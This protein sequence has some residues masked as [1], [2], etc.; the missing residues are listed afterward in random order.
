[1]KLSISYLRECAK[2]NDWLQ[3]I[4]HSQLHNYHPAEV[5]SLIQY[6]SPVIQDHLRLAFENLPLVPTSKM[7]INQVCNKSS[8]E[9][10]GSKEVMTDLFE[11]LL[12]CSE[13]PDSWHWLLV[14]AVKQQ[15]PILSV[16]ASCLQG[17]SAISCLCVWI[18]TSVE[19][20]VATEAMGHI[21]DSIEDHTWNLEDLSVIWRALLTRQK[22]KTLIR[23][24]QLFF[25]DSPLLLV[26]EMYELCMFFKNYKE[27]EAKLLEFQESL[28]ILNTAATKVH[29]VIPA[30][31]LEDQVCFLLK[32]MLQQCKTPY[33]L[34]KLLQLF[35]EREHLFSD[36]PDV[37]KLYVLCQILKDTSIAINHIIITCYSI[38]NF[39]HECKS[40]LE[41]LQTDGQFAL[42]RRVAELAEKHNM[43]ALCFSMCREIGENHEAA[44]RI[45]LKLIESQPW[46]DSLK[47]GHQLKQLLLKAL[48]LMLDAAESYAKDS[49][50]RQA[51]HC[52]RLTKL[53]T[54]QIHFLNTGQNTMLIN[55]GRHKLMD[56]ILALPRFYQASIVAEAYDFVPDWAEILYQQVILKG[57]FNY[58]EEFKQQRLLKSS[59]FEDISKK[60]KQH[61]PTDMVMENLKKLL[62]YCEDVYLYYK[63]AYE[64]KFYETVN[65]LLK[66]PQTGCC[67]KDMLA[68]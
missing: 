55:L 56:C 43:I 22:S 61:Q 3:F 35:V 15:A 49:C 34:G 9:L 27:A 4:I 68:G 5:K 16:L 45:Q 53:I 41:R 33:E 37:K 52:Q 65:V 20:S 39:Q 54:L 66:D 51:Q 30:M 13:E 63:L 38:E 1:M 24:F 10:Q 32:L 48:T 47:D 42:A 44:A 50:V 19:D 28:E 36:G 62:T 23:G 58:L 14:E 25:K 59:I 6:F 40:I 64:H 67:L 60:Y 31:W 18:I 11:I 46:E 57:D 7:D 21:Q 2:A 26:M 12:Q 8:Q 29:P 17:A